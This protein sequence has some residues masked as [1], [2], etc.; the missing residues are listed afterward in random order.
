MKKL[1]ICLLSLLL[2]QS[3]LYAAEQAKAADKD[4]Q[5]KENKKNGKSLFWEIT[6]GKQ[7]AYLF[8]YFKG[9]GDGLHFAYS[10]DGLIWKSVQNDKIFLKPQVGNE[11]LMQLLQNIFVHITADT[12][13]MIITFGAEMQRKIS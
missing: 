13:I 11:K 10:F 7:E 2:L 3:S 1:L 12:K 9:R 8:S 5:K 6:N 4:A